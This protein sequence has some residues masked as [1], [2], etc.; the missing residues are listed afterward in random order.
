M[1]DRAATCGA[2]DVAIVTGTRAT[3]ARFA[4]P[5]TAAWNIHYRLTTDVMPMPVTM[6]SFGGRC[7]H[8]QSENR[9]DHRD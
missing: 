6:T 7:R 1:A 2:A 8:R 3:G 9:S 5:V 4:I